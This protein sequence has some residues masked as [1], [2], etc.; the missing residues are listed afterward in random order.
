M[1][2]DFSD[3]LEPEE[4][5]AIINHVGKV[6]KH[7][8]RDTLLIEMLWQTG[9]RVTE[10]IQ[11]TQGGILSTSLILRNLKQRKPLRD[12]RESHKGKVVHNVS[13]KPI[14]MADVKAIKAVEV[15]K[16]LCDNLRAFCLANN[17]RRGEYV[18]QG[19]RNPLP[20]V[21]LGRYYVWWIVGK[22]SEAL[23]INKV[24][25][26]DP[27]IKIEREGKP[28]YPHL[29]RHATGMYLLEQTADLDLVRQHLGHANISTTQVYAYTKRGVIKRK[30][31]ELDW[32]EK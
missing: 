7:P 19:N 12:F 1:K 6:S 31:A 27:R 26:R 4:A 29:F 8:E 17:I 13:G 18:F 21:C 11:L 23:K 5:R 3:Y 22:A 20:H 25:K 30:I 32:G 15:S 2:H 28:A 14:M 9:A 16:A 24:G 10:A